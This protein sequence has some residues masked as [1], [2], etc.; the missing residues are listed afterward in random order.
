MI[1]Q[2]KTRRNAH[3][4]DLSCLR[5]QLSLWGL[6]GVLSTCTVHFLPPNKY[7][8]CFASFHLY[9]ILFLHN[10]RLCHWPLVQWLGFVALTTA[11]WPQSL[12]RNQSR[13]S[14]Y[15]GLRSVLSA[16]ISW[17]HISFAKGRILAYQKQIRNR[18]DPCWV[19]DWPPVSLANSH[20]ELGLYISTNS[21][22]WVCPTQLCDSV[23]RCVQLCATLWTVAHQAPLSMRFSRQEC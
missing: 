21:R 20:L 10:K 14:S 2:R 22:V 13:T 6:P 4:S 19:L 9:G 3:L 11:S 12:A 8:I 5:V 17:D 1:S 18:K 15:C 7:C 23:L 16:V